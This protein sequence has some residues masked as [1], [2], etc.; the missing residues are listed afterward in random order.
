MKPI[1]VP[2]K[3]IC[4]AVILSYIGLSQ[5]EPDYSGY[6]WYP[7]GSNGGPP[8]T[9]SASQVWSNINSELLT[10]F[11]PSSGTVT[12]HW[13]VTSATTAGDRIQ[14]RLETP[15]YNYYTTAIVGGCAGSG[16]FDVYEEM[17]A[18]VDTNSAPNCRNFKMVL[19]PHDPPR[20][21]GF[22]RLMATT[23]AD[24]CYL[25][26]PPCTNGYYF[27]I[28][29]PVF[30]YDSLR[31][32]RGYAEITTP[33][34]RNLDSCGSGDQAGS[35]SGS[36]LLIGNPIHAAT[37]DKAERVVDYAAIHRT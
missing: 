27:A 10:W 31:L 23:S 34:P 37:G 19:E 33:L 17:L 25:S 15:E 9:R 16:S 8:Y 5:A 28:R 1:D 24:V 6:I 2:I 11:Y 4:T 20:A 12:R 29:P 14:F 7:S 18:A 3:H 22:T 36:G 30:P 35:P 21:G 32:L 26:S 13:Y